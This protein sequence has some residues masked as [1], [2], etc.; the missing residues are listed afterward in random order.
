MH[1]TSPKPLSK[2]VVTVVLTPLLAK[3]IAPVPCIFLHT[4]MHLPQSMHLFWSL[5]IAEDVSSTA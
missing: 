1:L 5:T 2:A 3:S 4:L